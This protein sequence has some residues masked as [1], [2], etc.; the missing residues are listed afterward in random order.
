[1]KQIYW[2][3]KKGNAF[4]HVPGR[5]PEHSKSFTL[6]S[7]SANRLQKLT[8][9]VHLDA[10]K[11]NFLERVFDVVAIAPDYVVITRGR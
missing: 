2:N 5:Y 11:D 9:A 7:A 4:T 1:M 10:N 8:F 3:M 6:T